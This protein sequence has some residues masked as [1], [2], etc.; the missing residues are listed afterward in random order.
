MTLTQHGKGPD[1]SNFCDTDQTRDSFFNNERKVTQ[2]AVLS[3]A[4]VN[5]LLSCCLHCARSC[6][7][8]Y[9]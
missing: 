3:L 9:N 6:L 8:Q 2:H 4:T 5:I 1:T 7:K